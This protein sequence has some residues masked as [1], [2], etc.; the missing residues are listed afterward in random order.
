MVE[1]LE[2]QSKVSYR[3]PTEARTA[4]AMLKLMRTNGGP[5]AIAKGRSSYGKPTEIGAALGC[6]KFARTYGKPTE[7]LTEI[8]S[9]HTRIGRYYGNPTEAEI[10]C[11]KRVKRAKMRSAFRPIYD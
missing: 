5:T 3:G 4:L 10:S 2:A 9:T 8:G 1:K 7:L 11:S 6:S